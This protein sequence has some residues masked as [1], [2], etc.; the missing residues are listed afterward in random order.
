MSAL[1]AKGNKVI[2]TGHNIIRTHPRSEASKKW[3]FGNHRPGIHAELSCFLSLERD[4]DLHNHDL[5]IYR[6]RPCGTP[7]LA[8]PCSYCYELILSSTLRRIIWTTGDDNNPFDM[9]RLY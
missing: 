7:G 3:C 2:V 4:Y 5:Y 8:K 6:R 1:I 9:E